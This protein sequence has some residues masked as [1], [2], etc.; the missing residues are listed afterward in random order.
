MYKA[1]IDAFPRAKKVFPESFGEPLLHPDIVEMVR[2]AANAGKH[3]IL[4]TNGSLLD[5]YMS[6]AL[7]EAGLKELRISVDAH[8]KEVYERIRRGLSWDRLV[9]NV[10][11]FKEL[12]DGSIRKCFMLASVTRMEENKGWDTY[13]KKFWAELIGHARARNET[14]IPPQGLTREWSPQPVPPWPKQCKR[15][16]DVLTVK[17]DGTVVL[18][19][20]DWWG[21]FPIGFVS[22]IGNV[23]NY[24]KMLHARAGMRGVW[25]YYPSICE[26]CRQPPRRH[27]EHLDNS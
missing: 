3:V 22:D 21:Q 2:Y 1:I 19:C 5:G 9:H 12:R 27:R 16:F 10:L 7:L 4:V 8:E 14:D 20:N 11:M 13:T 24:Q 26:Y 15:P 6:S 18:C 23:F 17:V 25:G